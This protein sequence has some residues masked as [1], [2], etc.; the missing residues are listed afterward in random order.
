MRHKKHLFA[1]GTLVI[2]GLGWF[3][4]KLSQPPASTFVF[5]FEARIEDE[6]VAFRSAVGCF[7]YEVR[8]EIFRPSSTSYAIRERAFSGKLRSGRT[9]FVSVPD[10]C[11]YVRRPDGDYLI[12]GYDKWD[13]PTIATPRK[14]VP[15]TYIMS[16]DGKG[17]RVLVFTSLDGKSPSNKFEILRSTVRKFDQAADADLPERSGDHSDPFAP[18][19]MKSS[20]WIARVFLPVP[21]APNLDAA[22]IDT[23]WNAGRCDIIR[24]NEQGQEAIS[25]LDS[26]ASSIGRLWPSLWRGRA[27]SD[28]FVFPHVGKYDAVAAR[29]GFDSV[30]PTRFVGDRFEIQ[31]DHAGTVEFSRSDASYEDLSFRASSYFHNGVRLSDDGERKQLPFVIRCKGQDGL[32][33]PANLFF[34]RDVP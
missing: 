23:Q 17:P 10:I 7:P 27:L 15:L 21:D 16:N 20:D 8:G 3:W 12:A 31:P 30:I 18:A 34:S 32:Y 26:Y 13:R 4:W 29:T 11:A 1:I 5:E 6:T 19:M 22:W 33:V 24:V 2:A 14:I 28:L 9:F 25:T